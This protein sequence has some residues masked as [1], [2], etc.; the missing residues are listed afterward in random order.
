MGGVAPTG[1]EVYR[2]AMLDANRHA[3]LVSS[4]IR[5]VRAPVI[6]AGLEEQLGRTKCEIATIVRRYL[7]EVLADY[8]LSDLT[9]EVQEDKI[10]SGHLGSDWY[11]VPIQPSREPKRLGLVYSMLADMAGDIIE[12]EK[13]N[14]LPMLDDAPANDEQEA[15][16]EK[17]LATAS[18]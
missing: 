10:S 12:K 18:V 7:Q 17:P 6:V 14:V 3:D 15:Q 13:L 16:T 2:V 5:A 1:R 9:F 8:P 11:R 4:I